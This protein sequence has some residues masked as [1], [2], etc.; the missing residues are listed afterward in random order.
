MSRWTE[1]PNAPTDSIDRD[2]MVPRVRDAG[3]PNVGWDKLGG[4]IC[5]LCKIRQHTA[6]TNALQF[7]LHNAHALYSKLMLDLEELHLLIL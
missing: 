3:G 7:S 1:R 6:A 2:A 4:Y 5:D